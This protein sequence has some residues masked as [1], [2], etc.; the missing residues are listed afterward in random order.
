MLT[1]PQTPYITLCLLVHAWWVA[2]KSK[3]YVLAINF[4]TSNRTYKGSKIEWDE[5]E[6]AAP[7]PKPQFRQENAAPK[8]KD[9]APIANRF[10]LLNMD[11]SESGS[12]D[13]DEFDN[14][15]ITL[16]SVQSTALFV[17]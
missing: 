9:D 17:T 3:Q 15:G 12:L 2:R 13:D 14:S 10:H 8:K 1:F 6:C 4:L 16:S 11:D 7:L 5:D